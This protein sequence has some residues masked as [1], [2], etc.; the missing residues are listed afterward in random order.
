MC[1]RSNVK[2]GNL[3]ACFPARVYV[4]S[5]REY[6][7]ERVSE[8][9]QRS[10]GVETFKTACGFMGLARICGKRWPRFLSHKEPGLRNFQNVREFLELNF[11]RT[12]TENTGEMERRI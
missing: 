11:G 5:T 8:W 2:A 7:F 1:A 3:S 10:G 9:F 4:R 6:R 12:F